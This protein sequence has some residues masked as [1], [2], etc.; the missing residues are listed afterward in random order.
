MAAFTLIESSNLISH[1]I[2]VIEKLWNLQTVTNMLFYFRLATWRPPEQVVSQRVNFRTLTFSDK[3]IFQLAGGRQDRG[4]CH[5]FV[6]REVPCIVLSRLVHQFLRYSDTTHRQRCQIIIR[7]EV[8][9]KLVE[10]YPV[11]QNQ[12]WLKNSVEIS[13][14]PLL[15]FTWRELQV[16]PI[17]HGSTE[18][19]HA[20]HGKT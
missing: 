1:K 5:H 20:A 6:Y 3:D 2:W 18:F 4:P 15:T 9:G 16:Y 13:R 8:I 14:M 11:H 12:K 10:K 19:A 17:F 7:Y